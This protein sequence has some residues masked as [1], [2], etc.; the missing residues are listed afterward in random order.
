MQIQDE[1]LCGVWLAVQRFR[2]VAEGQ[3]TARERVLVAA[4]IHRRPD[5]EMVVVC[6]K[7]AVDAHVTSLREV[8]PVELGRLFVALH[9]VKKTSDLHIDVCGHVHHVADAGHQTA[10]AVGGGFGLA[11]VGRSLHRVDVVVVCARV[12]D[13][14][15]NF[16]RISR[17]PECP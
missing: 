16:V 6:L 4:L 13:I 5:T 11:G 1:E 9:G 12:C 8:L 7:E 14:S 3:L 10:Q 17:N 2:Q 15:R